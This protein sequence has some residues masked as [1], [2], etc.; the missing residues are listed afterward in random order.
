VVPG[1]DRLGGVRG[2]G[3]SSWSCPSAQRGAR[4]QHSRFRRASLSDVGADL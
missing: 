2:Q 1:R 4:R 3:K